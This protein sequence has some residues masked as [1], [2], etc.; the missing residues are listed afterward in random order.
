MT[1]IKTITAIAEDTLKGLSSNPKFLSSKYFYDEAGSKI[2]QDIMH[3][4]E[5]YLTDCEL[6]IFDQQKGSILNAFAQI[7]GSFDLI[8]LGAGDG[9]KTKVLLRH[10]LNQNTDFKYMPVDI[11]EM[12]LAEMANNLKEELPDLHVE[13]KAGDYF[14]MIKYINNSGSSAKIILFLGSNIGNYT[15]KESIDFFSQLKMQMQSHDRLFI[16]FDLKKDPRTILDAYNDPY[17]YTREFNLNLLR[18]L[19]NELGA[20]F[21]TNNFR[22]HAVYE[23]ISGAAK[24]YLVSLK[25]QKVDIEELETSFEFDAYEAI[26]MEMSQKYDLN[27]IHDLANI[28]GFEVEQNFFDT[29]KYFV[30]S[31][32]KLK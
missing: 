23:P 16:G 17:G 24:S 10:L 3:M 12:A 27:M 8:E 7:N 11:S 6:E 30:N 20:N 31:L 21:N 9:Y 1:E 13:A 5:Y 28:S 19:N 14:E 22:H 32:W 29:K 2:F 25:E 26:Y 4:P 18:R 15:W